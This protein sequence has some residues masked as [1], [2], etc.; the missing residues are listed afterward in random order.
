LLRIHFGKET[1]N[2]RMTAMTVQE[3]Y[4]K[5]NGD[6]EGV[7]SRLLSDERVK[8]YLLK[9]VNAKDYQEMLDALEKEDYE[10]AFRMSHN[11]KGVSLNLG[12]TGLQKTSNVLCE[13]LRGGKPTVDIEPLLTPVKEEYKKAVEAIG[14]L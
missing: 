4:E 14:E 6:Y 10:V 8:K 1:D 13:A 7:S 3:C 2:R 5:M 9:F 12:L 11:L